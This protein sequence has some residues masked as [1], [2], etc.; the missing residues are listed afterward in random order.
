MGRVAETL[1]DALYITDDNP[2]REDPA[3]IIAAI[4]SGLRAPQDAIVQHDRGAS[5]AAAL[6]AAQAGDVVLIAG[7]G[8]EDYQIIGTE[9]RAYSDL[10]QVRAALGA[11][12][13]A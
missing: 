9:R 4:L 7:K 3:A 2:R 5:I 11:R 10:V 8:H 1:A 12:S 13:A 6:G